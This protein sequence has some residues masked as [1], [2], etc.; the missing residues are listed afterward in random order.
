MCLL[1][2]WK[3]FPNHLGNS[4]C[5]SEVQP[6]HQVFRMQQFVPSKLTALDE[7]AY[8]PAK[9]RSL[10]DTEAS[11]SPQAKVIIC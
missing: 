11:H 1:L 9:K 6:L 8:Q 2:L 10:E 4:E 5:K 3:N 7:L